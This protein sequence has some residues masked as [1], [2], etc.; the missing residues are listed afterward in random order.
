M[1]IPESIAKTGRRHFSVDA[2]LYPAM[3]SQC[4]AL[5]GWPDEFTERAIPPI[6]LMPKDE[7]GRVLVSQEKGRFSKDDNDMIAPYLGDQIVEITYDQYQAA[8]VAI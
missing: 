6:E 8:K 1:T 7:S 3:E 5:R 4:A 2:T